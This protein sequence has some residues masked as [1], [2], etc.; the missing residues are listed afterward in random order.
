M[1]DSNVLT[2][3]I[4]SIITNP[5]TLTPED[6]SAVLTLIF[7]GKASDIQIGS[8][9]T[10]L[11]SKGIDH[12]PEFIAA[13]VRTVMKFSSPI[14]IKQVSATTGYVDIVGTG[15]D[16]QNTFNVSTASSI[17]AAGMGVPVC[18][19]GGKASTSASGSGDLL[20]CLGVDLMKVNK[21]TA[22][23]VLL[24]SPY[25]FLFAPAFHEVMANVASVRKQ[26][27][28]PT[29]FNILGP[30]MNPAPLAARILG[31]Y[32][33]PLGKAY[34]ECVL[35]LTKDDPTHVRTMVV[36][37]NIGLD[38]ISPIGT[39][40]CWIVENNQ[41]TYKEISP[42]DF[43]LP[44]ISLEN[45]KSGTPDQNAETLSHI[46]N[47][48]SP[49]FMVKEDNKDNHPILN[50]ILLNSAALA[51]VYGLVESYVEGVEVAKTAIK[52]FAAQK[53]LDLFKNSLELLN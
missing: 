49:E 39:T 22:I 18:K 1:S 32:S 2:P 7:Q 26:L 31:V 28:V 14:D 52:S 36:Y 11:R 19:H 3:Y 37:G 21:H 46:L 23:K 40:S 20:K 41:I 4:K 53:A 8:F 24:E 45:V 34:A 13:A 12:E 17:V 35:Q 30:L 9:L 47:Q 27:G 10:V 15:G 48:D 16:G 44:E 29:I 25:T 43:N 38:E 42:L 51:V 33:K 6:L 5:T 50:Y